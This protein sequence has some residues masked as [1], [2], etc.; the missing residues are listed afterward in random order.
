MSDTSQVKTEG[1]SKQTK[2]LYVAPSPHLADKATTRRLMLDVII[3]LVPTFIASLI[4]FRQHAIRL[5]VI[6][7]VSC[8]VTEYLFNKI[9]NK[10]NSLG[11]FSAVVTA[12]I[13]AFTLPPD[14]P[15]FAA[16]IGSVVAIAIGKMIFGGLGHNIFNPAM[17]GRAF[18]MA[19]FPVLMTTWISPSNEP[20][21]IGGI[22]IDIAGIIHK[23]NNSSVSK[24]SNLNVHNNAS[25]IAN[26]EANNNVSKDTSKIA[27]KDTS[28]NAN[29]GI[30]GTVRTSKGNTVANKG[31]AEKLAEHAK[32]EISSG[33][34]RTKDEQKVQAV[35]QATPLALLKPG[36]KDRKMP[37]AFALFIGKTGGSLGETSVL[38]I[39]IGA[40][41]LLAR[42]TIDISIPFGMLG[43]AF[44]FS[45]IA[46]LLAPGKFANPM[47][48]LEA[49]G[50][51][52]GAFF[53]ATDLVTTPLSKRGRWI[54]GAG[55]GILT[56]I[57][58]QFG[59]YPE[60]VMFSVLMMNGLAP[61]ISRWTK[62][63]PLGGHARG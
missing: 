60:G 26:S 47:Y 46:Y 21:R 45:G 19:A 39:L 33:T 8:L 54:F 23:V 56:M 15:G 22:D 14:L 36:K 59:T 53:I 10:P 3:A 34:K 37:N 12:L 25:K 42:G 44:I 48:H 20:V 32:N 58:R 50:L 52:F 27:N 16:V 24:A 29:K 41:Y 1:Q 61:L 57:I 13:L 40:L 51:L 17:V 31:G 11:D 9:R 4:F 30:G 6:C 62:Q 2:E 55:C 43:S 7:L 5:T 38:A 49:G 63:K 35:S 28:K 18:L